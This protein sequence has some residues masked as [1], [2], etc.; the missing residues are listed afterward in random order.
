MAS[1]SRNLEEALTEDNWTKIRE[2]SA[3]LRSEFERVKRHLSKHVL[4]NGQHPI[5]KDTTRAKHSVS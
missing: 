1:L 2:L 5:A 4:P 3:R